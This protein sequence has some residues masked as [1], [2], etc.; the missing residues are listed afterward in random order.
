RPG[1]W[2]ALVGGTTSALAFGST[3]AFLPVFVRERGLER[4][5][6]FFA[7]Y[8][9]AALLVRLL[10]GGLGDRLGYRRVAGVALVVFA[11]AVAAFPLVWSTPVLVGLALVY[12]TAH[13]LVYPSLNALF[14]AG[15][16][17]SSRGRAMALFTLS[18]NVGV[19][20]SAFAGGELAERL[21]FEALWLTMAALSLLGVIALVRDDAHRSSP[22]SRSAF[23]A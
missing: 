15:V 1:A 21:G 12:G 17:E 5:S 19:T 8:V 11:A 2:S 13:G 16:P 9:G 18:F 14:V 3:T 23:R 4:F 6:P 7:A 20:T 22:S 10:G